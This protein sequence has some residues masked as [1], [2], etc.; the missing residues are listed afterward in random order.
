MC[1]LVV[2]TTSQIPGFVF[3]KEKIR[4]S[5]SRNR[6]EAMTP[7]AS[8]SVFAE[9]KLSHSLH[10]TA[11]MAQKAVELDL[12]S[13]SCSICLNLLEDP[14]TIPCGHSY[15]M[16]CIN[17]YW[18]EKQVHSCPQC[19]STFTPRPTLLKNTML[20]VVVEQLKQLGCHAADGSYA[21]ET[22]VACDVCTGVKLKAVKSCLVCLVSYC[23]KHLQPH[24]ESATFQKH[25]LVEPSKTLQ[26]NICPHHNEVMRMFC[27]T[28]QQLICYICPVEEHGGHDTVSAAA[29]RTERQK[30]LIE[31]QQNIQQR[32]Q[33]REKDFQ[34]LEEE[35][36]A[37]NLS[38]DKA[39][40]DIDRFFSALLEILDQRCSDGRRQVRIM[41]DDEV[42]QA[43]GL[44]E[45]LQMEI[46]EL[47]KRNDELKELVLTEDH[48]HF[49]RIYP[50]L[51]GTG[52][53]ADSPNTK[54]CPLKRFEDLT[55]GLLKVQQR[56]QRILGEDWS[57]IPDTDT[58]TAIT[59][60]VSPAPMP[61]PK[62]RAEFL[63]Y[64]CNL[65]LDPNSAHALIVLSDYNRRATYMSYTQQCDIHFKRFLYCCQVLSRERMAGRCYW[66][67]SRKG[68]VYVAMSYGSI[69]RGACIKESGF[70]MNE[71]SW[72]LQCERGTYTFYHNSVP[73]AVFGVGS[74]RIGVYLDHSAGILSFYSVSQTMTLLH[75]IRVEFTQPLHAGLRFYNNF[76]D[77]A[78]FCTFQ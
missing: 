61:Q 6:S 13:F 31:V 1:L 28:D 74:N 11:K 33:E 12:E 15:C 19:R 21:G 20:A 41:Q 72:A 77:M 29:E 57:N 3:I 56:L 49:L 9:V 55:D 48:N 43:R 44:Q 78:E 68:R 50:S 45:K 24:Y 60:E 53:H 30:K 25:K 37:V 23:G 40:D 73:H 36:E 10:H 8:C 14:V 75:S 66:E 59:A 18:E 7:P 34:V 38:A 26:E 2:V 27:R 35:V 67:V 32:I 4:P 69:L 5:S 54:I 62:S 64:S 39:V 52:E 47:K 42:S 46:S 63:V 70:G 17:C 71:H 76:G 58:A 16:G 51:L 65:T 22:D